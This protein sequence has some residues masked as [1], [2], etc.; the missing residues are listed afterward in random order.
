VRA[1]VTA[2]GALAV[3]GDSMSAEP[4]SHRHN[5]PTPLTSFI[6]REVELVAVGRMLQ[7]YRLLTLTGAGGSGKTRL[8]LHAA[9]DEVTHFPAGVW[10]VDLAPLTRPELVAE[11]I[12]QALG[13]T[14]ISGRPVADVLCDALRDRR[15]LLV[16][17]NCEHLA[18]ECAR[19]VALMLAQCPGVRVLATSREPLGVGGEAVLQVPTLSLPDSALP[20][21]PQRLLQSDAACLFVERARAADG[22]F[23]L[24][25]RNAQAVADICARLDG[26][27][28][29]LELAAPRVRGMPLAQ[30]AN[31]L[32]DRFRLLTGGDPSAPARQQTL[33]ALIDWSHSLLDE[34]ERVVFRRLAVFAPNWPLEAA[35]A[36]CA[37][38][39]ATANGS[40]ALP[41]GDVLGIV[42]RL[43]DRSLVQLDQGA[44]RY[45]LLETIRHY[46]REKLEEAGETEQ[47]SRRHFTW[48][49]RLAEEG[50]PRMGGPGERDWLDTL[51]QERDNAS[52]A[53]AWAIGEGLAEDAAQLAL[54]L[55]P[56]WQARWYLREGQQW[57]EQIVALGEHTPL[58]PATRARLLNALGVIAHTLGHFDRAGVCHGEAIRLWRELGDLDG[59]AIA[60]L[61]HGWHYFYQSNLEQTRA[62]ADE[63]LA[64]ARQVG[65]RRTIAAALYLRASAPA[66]ARTRWPSQAEPF[67]LDLEECLQIWRELGD[68]TS[69]AS[70]LSVLALG[71]VDAGNFERAKLLLAEALASHIQMGAINSLGPAFVGLLQVAIHDKNQPEG[72]I[73][74]AQLMG[75]VLA[76]GESQGS[77][78]MPLAQAANEQLA[79]LAKGSLGEELFAR[80]FAAGKRLSMPAFV[81]LATAI[82][83]PEPERQETR[84]AAEK[85]D[86]P[87]DLTAREV[88]VLRLVAAGHSNPQIAEQLVVSTRTVEAHLRS[89]F[90]K[91]EVTSRTAAARFALEHG[92]V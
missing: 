58:A 75:A 37:G 6:G 13:V 40:A 76:W 17:D 54:A 10:F 68:A 8:A 38:D 45:R 87:N 20:P 91:L 30:L 44:G 48:Y 46:C 81:A 24:T 51:E 60:L 21:D 5:L 11:R 53:L 74:A 86:Y 56:F 22:A 90:A 31:R 3:V 73:Q 29:A 72:M 12:A 28:L 78:S 42:L 14:D 89:I 27:P 66:L 69:V 4:Q 15:L 83:Q 61:D 43:V 23:R 47:S 36:I 1:S 62:C 64:L 65:N 80:E 85:G 67:I 52:A 7:E 84:P 59:L 33:H 71:E 63:S 50:A 41:P 34:R 16:L 9:A 82:T 55:W 26:L 70:A 49:L 2:V 57:L 35:E 39:Y 32:G 88:E 19:L 18:A 92:L 25:E 77:A 79:A